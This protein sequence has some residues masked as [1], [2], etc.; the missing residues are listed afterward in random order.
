MGEKRK[1]KKKF[2]IKLVSAIADDLWA[3]IGTM[4]E[5]KK[6][7]MAAVIKSLQ[8]DLFWNDCLKFLSD[9]NKYIGADSLILVKEDQLTLANMYRLYSIYYLTKQLVLVGNIGKKYGEK[10]IALPSEQLTQDAG[11]QSDSSDYSES[12]FQDLMSVKQIQQS[13]LVFQNRLKELMNPI[14]EQ[15][16]ELDSVH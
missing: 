16:L 1:I 3:K 9:D 4:M 7:D 8:P 15:R 13:I 2:A 5:L 11:E 6:K 14:D 10:N 12:D